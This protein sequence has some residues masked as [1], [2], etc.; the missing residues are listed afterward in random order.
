MT[1]ISERYAVPYTSEYAQIGTAQTFMLSTGCYAPTTGMFR[2]QQAEQAFLSLEN[3]QLRYKLNGSAP[4]TNCGHLFLAGDYMVLDHVEQLQ[5]LKFLKE[6]EAS[7]TA[8]LHITY[9]AG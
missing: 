6:A 1:F 4:A 2:G 9:F 8:Y 3:A 5:N 7:G